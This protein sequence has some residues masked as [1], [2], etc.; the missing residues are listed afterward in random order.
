MG[1]SFAYRALGSGVFTSFFGSF[2]REG[3]KIDDRKRAY[4]IIGTAS[5]GCCSSILGNF[6]ARNNHKN[7]FQKRSLVEKAP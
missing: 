2:G 4:C 1:I 6:H 7:T 3:P 5:G